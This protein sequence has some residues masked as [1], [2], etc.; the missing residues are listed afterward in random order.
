MTKEE[1]KEFRQNVKSEGKKQ[2]GRHRLISIIL[3]FLLLFLGGGYSMISEKARYEENTEVSSSGA[4]VTDAVSNLLS[5]QT[6]IDFSS[7][8]DGAK[9]ITLYMIGAFVSQISIADSISVGIINTVNMLFF[10]K[11]A[12]RSLVIVFAVILFSLFIIFVKNIIEI[13]TS[14]VFLE[15]R[16]YEDTSIE[17]ATMV[18]RYGRTKHTAF[19][20]ML[21]DLKLFLWSF[22]IVGGVIKG[23]EYSMLPCI[24]AENPDISAKDAFALTRQLTYGRK[25]DLFLID[26][27]LIP[28]YILSLLSF[29][30]L[31]ILHVGPYKRW[32]YVETYMHLRSKGEVDENLLALL[33][34]HA[35]D[36]PIRTG[37]SYPRERFP[38]T[39]AA[40]TEKNKHDISEK[41]SFTMLVL[42]FFTF[43]VAGYLFEVFYTMLNLGV[44]P[45]PGLLHGPWLSLY[46]VVGML[47]L[48]ILKKNSKNPGQ[49]FVMAFISCAVLQYG[50]GWLFEKLWDIKLFD[51]SG[52]YLNLDGRVC[53]E[54]LLIFALT[55]ITLTYAFAPILRNVYSA[56]PKKI[57]IL[58]CIVLIGCYLADIVYSFAEIAGFFDTGIN[59]AA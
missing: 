24:L 7:L 38:H 36:L 34:D 28:L 13:G 42:F 54:V 47:M 8:D 25:K 27:S 21:R 32:I 40:L 55:G 9:N 11:S 43:S 15:Q 44:F 23:Y 51:Y 19:I 57:T 39:L 49:A 22:T 52:Y 1:R 41:Y 45:S 48:F 29:G 12:S 30:V 16:K 37:A 4:S 6:L 33:N 14:R 18:Y 59:V 20:L 31:E 58:I 53:L 2:L 35:L 17:N 26:V 50:T 10:R 3:S 46:G 56:I 5:D